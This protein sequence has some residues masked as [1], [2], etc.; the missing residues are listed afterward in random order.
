MGLGHYLLVGRLPPEALTSREVAPLVIEV[1]ESKV[2]LGW[3]Y[4]SP[5]HVLL[6]ELTTL[7]RLLPLDDLVY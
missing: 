3:D 4:L 5:S 6:S 2:S 7:D 1:V